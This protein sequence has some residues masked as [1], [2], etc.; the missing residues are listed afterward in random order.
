MARGGMKLTNNT[1]ARIILDK[2]RLEQKKISYSFEYFQ[3]VPNFGLDGQ[4]KTWF[5]ALLD[6]LKDLSQKDESLFGDYSARDTYRL[7]TINWE[8]KNIP[9]Q[10]ADFDWIPSAIRDNEDEYPFWQFELSTALGRV[11]GYF[12]G[13]VFYVLLLDPKHNMQPSKSYGY[14]VNKTCICPSSY[15]ELRCKIEALREKYD[16]EF[17]ELEEVALHHESVDF[18]CMD[19]EL[20]DH[21]LSKM[22]FKEFRDQLEEFLICDV[23]DRSE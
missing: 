13:V 19:A 1:P 18:L 14:K 7:H 22:S 23:C 2:G 11:I 3:Q 21:F 12:V 4:N 10:R 16:D 20:I 6:R 9:L 5:I 8:Q 15:E 17:P